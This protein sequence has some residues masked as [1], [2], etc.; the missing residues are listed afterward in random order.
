MA[1]D[2]PLSKRIKRHVIGRQRTYFAAAAP[3]FENLCYSELINIGLSREKVAVVEGG[4][5]FQGKLQD[6]W[7]ANL[8]LRT[9]NRILLRIESFKATGFSQLENKVAKIPWELYL[10]TMVLPGVHVTT[11]HCRLH[12]TDAISQR[13]IDGISAHNRGNNLAKAEKIKSP[14]DLTVFVRG[15]DDRFTVSIDSSGNHLHK[16]GLKTHHGE[17]PI[18][19]TVAAAALLLLGYTGKEP[20]IDPMCGAG[21]FS[22]EAALMAKNIAPGWFREFAYMQWPSFSEKRWEYLKRQA[23]SRIVNS[24]T[25][26]IFASDLDNSACRRLD[27]CVRKNQLTDIISVARKNFFELQPEA[28]TEKKGL[29]VINPPYG[30]RLGSLKKSET[31]F[32]EIGDRLTQM[33][34]GWKVA[35]IAPDKRWIKRLPFELENRPFFHGGLKPALLYGTIS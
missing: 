9:A 15:V 3:G 19:E 10:P 26:M 8:H 35:L 33:Y 16:R 13:I 27:K 31:I 6:C 4:V 22:L 32:A 29:V 7:L 12:H 11:R 28:L 18:R 2:N 17:A 30:K 34:K 1:V 5:A 25:P 20:L 14:S 24:Q 21:T 23:K